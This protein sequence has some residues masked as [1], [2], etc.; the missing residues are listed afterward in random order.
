MEQVQVM[1]AA[2]A[3]AKDDV[4]DA[5]E[6]LRTDR[7]QIDGRVRGFLDSGWSG[8]AADSFSEAWEE[9]KESAGEVLAGLTAM[10]ELLD[11]THRDFIAS[12]DSSQQR[13]DALSA[14]IIDR[15][16]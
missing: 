15:L 2:F 13:L 3:K 9:W 4:H 11:E 16:G 14:R 5:A 8:E 1:H 10:R 7:S 12:D 6:R